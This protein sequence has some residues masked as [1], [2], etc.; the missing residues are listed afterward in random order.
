MTTRA[1]LLPDRGVLRVEG[2]EASKFLQGLLTNDVSHLGPD[3]AA[4]AALL[5]PQGKILFE[6]FVVHAEDAYFLETGVALL[7]DLQKKLGFYKLRAKV[8]ISDLTDTVDVCAIWGG[9]VASDDV[10]VY[11]DPRLPTLGQRAILPK[12]SFESLS[13]LAHLE[14]PDDYHAHRILAG[15]PEAGRDYALGDTF[16]HEADMDQLRGVDFKKGCFV[17]QEV[18]SRMQ[19]RATTRKRVVPVRYLGGFRPIEG[20]E[21]RAGEIAIGHAGSALP[22]PEDGKPVLGLAL[23]RL[24]K[25]AD[26]IEAKTPIMCAGSL[27]EVLT[28]PWATFAIEPAKP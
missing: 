26:A 15:V 4:H 19:H 2:E 18:V 23:L 6:M 16:P 9:T 22:T 14:T 21:V 7:P 20:A 27:V 24:D 5:S 13:A 28:P 1:S 8:A 17:G 3:E 10:L 12:G 25:A 11:T